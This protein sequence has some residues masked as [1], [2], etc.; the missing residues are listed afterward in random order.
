MCHYCLLMTIYDMWLSIGV[1]FSVFVI[2]WEKVWVQSFMFFFFLFF[3]DTGVSACEFAGALWTVWAASV[4]DWQLRLYANQTTNCGASFLYSHIP[5]KNILDKQKTSYGECP[6]R[7]AFLVLCPTWFGTAP[8]Q[9]RE[10]L[11]NVKC[12]PYSQTQVV[13]SPHVC[14][15]M[16]FT[17]L[18]MTIVVLFKTSVF[19]GLNMYVQDKLQHS[20]FSKT[21]T[22]DNHPFSWAL[23]CSNTATWINL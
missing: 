18:S 6:T 13:Q 12:G 3:V 15:H 17:C 10:F 19:M 7:S 11:R 8:R 9:L 20:C 5:K 2:A 1:G 23:S 16:C 22:K 4:R 21:H 14:I